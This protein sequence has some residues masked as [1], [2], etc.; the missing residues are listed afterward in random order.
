MDPGFHRGD[1]KAG[2]TEEAVD[3]KSIFVQV[4]RLQAE[5]VKARRDLSV[6]A[7]SLPH[8]SQFFPDRR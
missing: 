8:N 2:K 4:S 7:M 1:D 5:G 3:I 6:F